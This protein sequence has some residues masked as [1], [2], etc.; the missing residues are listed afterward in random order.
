[1]SE[2]KKNLVSAPEYHESYTEV[3]IDMTE[4]MIARSNATASRNR[5]T[6][7]RQLS[8][9]E[10]EEVVC[11]CCHGGCE[12]GE[13]FI[14]PCA[15]AGSV[16]FVHRHCLDTWRSV[17]Q[18][19]NSFYQCDICHEKYQFEEVIENNNRTQIVFSY[20]KYGLLVTFD[21]SLLVFIWQ[22]MVV[23]CSLFAHLIYL[24]ESIRMRFFPPGASVIGVDYLLGNLLFFF[25]LGLLGIGV[26]FLHLIS[27]CFDSDSNQAPQYTYSTFDYRRH[28]YTRSDDLFWMFYFF[29]WGPY[30]GYGPSCFFFSP[31]CSFGTCSGDCGNANC[32]GDSNGSG[33][34]IIGIIVLV[35][36]AIIICIGV[37]IGIVLAISLVTYIVHKRITVIK[38]KEQ[39]TKYRVADLEDEDSITV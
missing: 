39:I 22:I 6:S 23:L 19:P 30:S 36:V 12:D 29:S 11:R 32:G 35:I 16:K 18:N 24:G 17:S 2:E 28:S 25:V 26:G 15:C 37:I 21:I 34:P 1:M 7:E 38:K 33:I 10:K 31:H 8:E 4:M 5:R 3:A 27:K 9:R 13:D 20:L 14:A